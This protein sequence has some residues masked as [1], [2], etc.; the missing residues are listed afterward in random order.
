MQTGSRVQ[1]RNGLGLWG[2]CPRL[3]HPRQYIYGAFRRISD[4]IIFTLT[5]SSLGTAALGAYIR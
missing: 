3:S 5:V 4:V 2:L 1:G